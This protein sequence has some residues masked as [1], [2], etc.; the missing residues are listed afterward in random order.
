V[1]VLLAAR[2]GAVF[3]TGANWDEFALL[4]RADATL[5]SGIFESGGR[6]G[7]AVV[8][9][10]PFVAE[11]VDEIQVI[12]NARLLW[13]GVTLL[14]LTG[15]GVLVAQLQRDPR[16]RLLDATVAVGLLALVPAFLEWSI[17]VRSDQLALASGVWGGVALLASRRRPA[18]A[19]LAGL[20]LGAGFLASQKLAY[21]ALLVGILAVGDLALRRELRPTRELART[22]LGALAFAGVIAAFGAVLDASFEVPEKHVTKQMVTRAQVA[23]SLSLFDYYRNTIGLRQYAA[24]LPTLVPHA[25]ALLALFAATLLSIRERRQERGLLALAWAVLA[26]GF[27]VGAFHAGAFAY[28]WMTLGLF[29]A[30]AFAVARQPLVALFRERRLAGVALAAWWLALLGPALLESGAL[31]QDSQRVQRESF[32]FIHRN[33]ER[34]DVGFHPE[35]GLFCQQGGPPIQIHF[36]Q[37]IYR[38]F[39]GEWSEA[40]GEKMMRTF[41]DEPVKFI[42]QS[43]R[44]NQ[45]PVA[46]RRFWAENYQPYQASVFVA[47][48]RLEGGAG[49]RHDFDLLVPGRYRWLPDAGAPPLRVG[50][51]LVEPGAVV[52]LERGPNRAQTLEDGT[53]GLLVLALAQ[54]PGT[55][56]Q[57]FYKAY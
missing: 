18:L 21:V 45:F 25:A 10:L 34:S 33:L 30:V 53:S 14:F 37:T 2:L 39:G 32:A 46:L 24:M 23:R 6:P 13:L 17:Q 28:F 51:E 8:M 50:D 1:L 11:C 36:S 12:R 29:P 26:G 52:S 15:V 31:L 20:L 9:L 22:A 3:T 5:E 41:R 19:L 44:L 54:P 56:P 43:F 38:R 27:A 16:R 4:D 47:G 40:N 48:R 35:K 57:K 55:A 42:L 7:L 49:T